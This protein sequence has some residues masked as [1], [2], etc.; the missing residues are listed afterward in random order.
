[1][2]KKQDFKEIEKQ[3]RKTREDL[4]DL[5]RYTEDLIAFLPVAYC[6]LS[7]AG[8]IVD[9]NEAFE[10]LTGFGIDEANGMSAED[11]FIESENIKQI[12]EDATHKELVGNKE[13][14]LLS[15][16]NKKIPVVVSISSRKDNSGNFIGYFLSMNNITEFKKL[17]DELEKKVEE[18]TEELY[19]RLV[20]L[21]RFRSLTEGRELKMIELKNTIIKLEEKINE[22]K[23]HGKYGGK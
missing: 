10:R 20:D 3:L 15:G 5:E 21:E 13:L 8:K 4:E 22:M 9:A 2:N 16:E 12:L 1:M 6:F 18:R 17:Q 23:K 19:E 14:T 11:L 7:G